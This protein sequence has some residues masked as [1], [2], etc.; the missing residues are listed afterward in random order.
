ME[1]KSFH[2]HCHNWDFIRNWD[3]KSNRVSVNR[4]HRINESHNLPESKQTIILMSEIVY[5]T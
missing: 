2:C 5:T 3:I 4:N 1:I